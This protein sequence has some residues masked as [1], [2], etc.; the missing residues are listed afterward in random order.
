MYVYGSYQYS[1]D[2]KY[3]KEKEKSFVSSLPTDPSIIKL[4]NG[5]F[6]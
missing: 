5:S 4:M 6:Q 1:V 2:A 3:T